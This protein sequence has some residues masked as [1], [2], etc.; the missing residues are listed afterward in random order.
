LS[1]VHYVSGDPLA[2]SFADRDFSD[3]SDLS[4]SEA[5]WLTVARASEGRL[6]VVVHTENGNTFRIIS[7]RAATPR[8]KNRYE[9]R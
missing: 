5:R 6:L 4:D 8:E 9:Q 3:F 2:G 7:A 1:R